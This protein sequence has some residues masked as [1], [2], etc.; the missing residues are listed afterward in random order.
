MTNLT[1]L[2]LVQVNL[3]RTHILLQSIRVRRTRD[4][5][6]ILALEQE[7]SEHQL[8]RR[9]ALLASNLLELIDELEVLGEVLF[10]EA[11]GEFSEVAFGDIGVGLEGAGEEA[12]ADGGVC[13]DY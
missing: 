4:R 12:S 13:N 3:Q 2:L 7:P 8:R 11:R 5:E 1:R 9:D 6:D 10:A